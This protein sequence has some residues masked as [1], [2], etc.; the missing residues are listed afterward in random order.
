MPCKSIRIIA[1]LAY[2]LTAACVMET[3]AEADLTVISIANEGF[4]IDSGSAQVLVDAVFTESWGKYTVPG[5]EVLGA[6]RRAE[7]IFGEVDVFLVTH[8]HADHF[9]P[10][11]V[12]EFMRNNKKAVLLAPGDA[13]DML[14]ALGGFSEIEPRVTAL[15]P[16]WGQAVTETVAGIT[17][18]AFRLKHSDDEAREIQHLGFIWDADDKVFFHAGDA[19]LDDV[20]EYGSFFDQAGIDIAFVPWWLLDYWSRGQ[21]LVERVRPGAMYFMHA[22]VTSYVATKTKIASHAASLPPS[23][24]P[25][26]A[27][28]TWRFHATS[29]GWEAY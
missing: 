20:N 6:M 3:Q 24:V 28:E 12:L 1:L 26:P 29:N 16:A 22:A 25:G 8:N 5:P 7:G 11:Y 9:H 10:G 19:A 14:A 2:A 23:Y 27:M 13:V 18:T 15:T 21:T 17:V 4:L